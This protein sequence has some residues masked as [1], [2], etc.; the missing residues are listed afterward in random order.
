MTIFCRVCRGIQYPLQLEELPICPRVCGGLPMWRDAADH[1]TCLP[2]CLVYQNAQTNSPASATSCSVQILQ[3]TYRVIYAIDRTFPEDT[4]T[5]Q[6]QPYI[7]HLCA[8][9]INFV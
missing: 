7:I 5:G 1:V 4:L 9:N 3:N 2:Q 6:A 8:Q